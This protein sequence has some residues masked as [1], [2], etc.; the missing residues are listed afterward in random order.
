[1]SNEEISKTVELV[2]GLLALGVLLFLFV[3]LAKGIRNMIRDIEL[4]IQSA[5]ETRQ[6]NKRLDRAR[7]EASSPPNRLMMPLPS[8]GNGKA[9]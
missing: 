1:M 2:T 8:V 3:W 5:I 7:A 4:E 6:R 9:P